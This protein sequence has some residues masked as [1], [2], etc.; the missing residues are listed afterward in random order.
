MSA[1]LKPVPRPPQRAHS[2]LRRVEA[3]A[4]RDRPTELRPTPTGQLTRFPS[5]AELVHRKQPETKLQP[6]RRSMGNIAPASR[7]TAKKTPNRATAVRSLPTTQTAPNW[8]K[9][10]LVLQHTSGPLALSLVTAALVVYGWTVHVQQIW[11]SNFH[12][13]E[14]LQ[15]QERNLTTYG[16]MVNHQ[17]AKQAEAPEANLTLPGPQ[18]TIFL[19]PPLPQPV[20]LA[21]PQTVPPVASPVEV[22]APMGY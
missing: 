7:G 14:R 11:S 12:Q 17:I 5:R 1:A 4:L 19:E 22:K 20:P 8:L 9:L 18:N 15:Q 21:Q 2:N 3:L 16:Q 10:L 6:G 13:L